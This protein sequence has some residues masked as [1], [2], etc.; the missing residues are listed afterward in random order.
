MND[1]IIGILALVFIFVAYFLPTI[2][3]QGRGHR[4]AIPITLINLFLGWTFLGWVVALVWSAT[5]QEA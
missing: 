3:A 2:I 1:I 5:A 4:Q